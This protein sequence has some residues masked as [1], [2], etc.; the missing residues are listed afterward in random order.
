MQAVS[1]ADPEALHALTPQE[2]GT[3]LFTR[4]KDH[5]RTIGSAENLTLEDFDC[6]YLVVRSAWVET[7][8]D[9][10]IDWFRPV[11]NKEMKVCQGFGKHGDSAETRANKRSAWDT[12]HAG[13]AWATAEDNTPG[14]KTVAE[15]RAEIAGHYAKFPPKG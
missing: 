1:K 4:L 14:K 5:N 15:I 13:R 6:R 2:Q 3:P 12:L 10:L 9:L 11:W 7:A 8:E